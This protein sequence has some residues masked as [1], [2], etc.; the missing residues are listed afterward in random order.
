M[1]LERHLRQ[2]KRRCNLFF[3]SLLMDLERH[4]RRPKRYSNLFFNSRLMDLERRFPW[5]RGDATCFFNSL[6][7][8]GIGEPFQVFFD[9]GAFCVAWNRSQ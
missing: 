4:F 5:S 9:F 2:R 7:G 6:S 3:N 1:D 8:S